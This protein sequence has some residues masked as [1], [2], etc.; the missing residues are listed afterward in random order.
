[1]KNDTWELPENKSTIIPALR[2]SCQYLPPNLKQCFAYCS[3]FPKD[4]EFEKEELILSLVA[5]GLLQPPIRGMTL[6]EVGSSYF[7]EST[8]IIFSAFSGY[9]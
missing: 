5:E 3:T 8:S 1:M 7:D 6:E 4:Y 2:I 9:A